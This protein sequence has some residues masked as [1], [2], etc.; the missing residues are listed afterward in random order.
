M[1]KL[2]SSSF[3]ERSNEGIQQQSKHDNLD[4]ENNHPNICIPISNA[5]RSDG[6]AVKDIPDF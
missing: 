3:Q 6:L 1:N 4:K 5:R 2:H